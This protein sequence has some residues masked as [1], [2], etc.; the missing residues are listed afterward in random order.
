M[1][2]QSSGTISLSDL[3][4]HL[5]GTE[6]IG[7]DEYYQNGADGYSAGLTGIPNTGSAISVN[8]F[9]GKQRNVPDI[10]AVV[11][12]MNGVT[13]T[14]ILVSNNVYYY[15]FTS[16]TDTYAFSC[17]KSIT[18]D[19]LLIGGGGGG[20][21]NVGAGGGAGACIVRIG[22]ILSPNTY[23]VAVGAGG[24][25]AYKDGSTSLYGANGGDSSIGN[26]FVAKGGGGGANADA[27]T[28]RNG[29]NGGCGGG[30]GGYRPGAGGSAV[31]TNVVNGTT[32]GPTTTT[33]HVVLGTKGGN[34]IQWV[35]NNYG[36]LESAGGG[37]I[38]TAGSNA[39]STP[40][41][42][43]GLPGNG[44]YQVTINSTIYNLKDHFSPSSTFG[45]NN[46]SGLFYIGGGGAGAG[47][48]SPTSQIPGG[49]GGG[50]YSQKVAGTRGFYNGGDGAVNTGSGGGSGYNRVADLSI[51][52]NGGSGLVIIR[53][54]VPIV[55][56]A[57]RTL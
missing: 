53:F 1:V 27:N 43:P 29:N 48:S 13:Q 10:N 37:G 47:V 55:D 57:N 38:G 31:T 32:T 2:L 46:G 39:T 56:Y 12:T 14:P 34:A 51:G 16:A 52:G 28:T 6:P 3:Q 40:S 44:V 15:A 35:A 21:T 19:L 5:G 24:R 45:V 23:T 30:G 17:S 18:C 42:A 41:Y 54:T 20:S 25:G 22:Y 11:I 4:T 50:G 33:T 9:Y 49:L 8:Q 7:L 36:T 26:L